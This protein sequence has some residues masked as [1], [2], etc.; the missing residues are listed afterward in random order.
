MSLAEYG[1]I[2]S[3]IGGHLKDMGRSSSKEA[4]LSLVL[5]NHKT[6]CE[7]TVEKLTS[8]KAPACIC[9]DH[10]KLIKAFRQLAES[11]ARQMKS[12]N[13]HDK[14]IDA[15]TYKEGKQLEEQ[16]FNRIVH[17]LMSLMK[18]CSSLLLQQN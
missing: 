5:T 1:K 3:D 7:T 9:S 11:Y 17:I 15:E 4:A 2:L 10:E 6:V 12:L 18:N 13:S 8:I 16:E 14:V